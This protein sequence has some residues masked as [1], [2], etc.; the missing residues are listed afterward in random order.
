MKSTE[1]EKQQYERVKE[2]LDISHQR[3]LAAGGNPKHTHSGLPGEDFLTA[4]ER[5]ELVQL[6]RLL[7][8]TRTIGD[9]VHCQGRVWKVPVHEARNEHLP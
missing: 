3:Y 8:G 2:L 6:M 1:T 7:A 5:E 9:E 4:E